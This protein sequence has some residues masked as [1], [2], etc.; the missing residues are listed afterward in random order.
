MPA[1]QASAYIQ[2]VLNQYGLGSLSQWAMDQMINGQSEDQI[3]IAM[4][5]TPEFIARFPAIQARRDAGLAPISPA[6]YIEYESQARQ[7]MMSAGLPVGFYDQPSDYAD[8]LTKD[9]SL[10]ELQ[11]RVQSGYDRVRSAPPQVMEAFSQYYGADAPNALAQF[12][13]DPERSL[14]DLMRQAEAAVFGGTGSQ[15]GV[16]IN[17]DQ[18]ELASR[19]G[20]TQNQAQ[21]GFQG[22]NQQQA[23]YDE[24]FNETNDLQMNKEGVAATFGMDAV[25]ERAVQQRKDTRAAAFAG[26]D[27]VI[28][29][30]SG[31]IGTGAAKQ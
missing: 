4:E 3:M 11:Q 2:Q 15:Y 26:A 21:Q 7:M 24:N 10:N 31:L 19:M 16:G 23:Y 29:S 30:N 17:R 6:A 14:P 8:L 28:E 12:Y 1:D 22:L 25:S 20:I 27:G 13:L 5:K 9:V 18:A